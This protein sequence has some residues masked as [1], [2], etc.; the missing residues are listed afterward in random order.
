[1]DKILTVLVDGI[2]GQVHANVILQGQGWSDREKLCIKTVL[3]K[4]ALKFS[5]KIVLVKIVKVSF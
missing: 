3:V 5:I 1:M 2:V 4:I